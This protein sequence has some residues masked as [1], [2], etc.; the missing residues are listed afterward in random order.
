M[1]LLEKN[2]ELYILKNSKEKLIENGLLFNYDLIKSQLTIGNYGVADIVTLQRPYMH[3]YF[4]KVCRGLITVYELKKDN[5]TAQSILQA[6]KYL[7]GI[8]SYLRLRGKSNLYNY[9]IV[10]IGNKCPDISNVKYLAS[11]FNYHDNAT[12][13]ILKDDI[14]NKHTEIS[15]HKICIELVTYNYKDGNIFFNY[16]TENFKELGG[17]NEK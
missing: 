1:N 11:L 4:N 3:T 8:Y 15:E 9:R 13:D 12:Q 2:V 7:H 14:Y 17:F 10:L 16:E 5:I 6:S